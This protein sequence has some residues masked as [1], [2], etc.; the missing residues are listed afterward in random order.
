MNVKNQGS[1]FCFWKGVGNQRVCG[2]E[3]KWSIQHHIRSQID[4]RSYRPCHEEKSS[5][6]FKKTRQL[7]SLSF[8]HLFIFNGSADC[9]VLRLALGLLLFHLEA[10]WKVAPVWCFDVLGNFLC[11]F[12]MSFQHSIR[13]FAHLPSC[14]CPPHPES[15]RF[16]PLLRHSCKD[17][18]CRE[19]LRM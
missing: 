16:R 1:G 11:S 8:C 7:L 18:C 6:F 9:N 10:L 5:L 4:L 3:M 17:S 14:P 12:A 15:A 19:C 2:S 13:Q